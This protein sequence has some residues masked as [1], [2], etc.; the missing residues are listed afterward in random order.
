MATAVESYRID[1]NAYPMAQSKWIPVSELASAVQ[2][3][4]IRTAPTER[5]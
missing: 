2:P 1:N 4:Y 5:R 3:D